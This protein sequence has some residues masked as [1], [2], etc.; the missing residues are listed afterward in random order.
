MATGSYTLL[1]YINPPAGYVDISTAVTNVNL[2]DN[3][4]TVPQ[5]FAGIVDSANLSVAGTSRFTGKATFDTAPDF[6]AGINVAISE[7]DTGTL[8][9][10]GASSLNGGLTVAGSLALPASSIVQSMVSSGY[11][12]L[13]NAQ[14]I[15]GIKTLSSPPVMSGAS[16]SSA[17]IPDSALS[18]NVA[19][20][21]GSQTFSGAKTFSSAVTVPAISASGLISGSAGLTISTG[22]TSLRACSSTGFTASGPSSF[23]DVTAVT[24]SFAGLS[25]SAGVTVTAGNSTLQDTLV[26]GVLTVSSIVDAGALSVGALLSANNGITVSNAVGTFNGGIS[27]STF[28]ASGSASFNT[29]QA[30]GAVTTQANLSVNGSAAINGV[31]GLSVANGTSTLKAATCTDLTVINTIVGTA[32]KVVISSDNTNGVYPIPFTKVGG[33]NTLFCDD[34]VTPV[35]SYNPSNGTLSAGA[36]T[37]AGIITGSGGLNLT[38]SVV[39]NIGIG[40]VVNTANDVTIALGGTTFGTYSTTPSA[41]VNTLTIT[42][43]AVCATFEILIAP[44]AAITWRKAMSS[45]GVTIYNNLAGNQAM[46]NGS[47]WWVK[48]KCLSATIIYLDFMNVT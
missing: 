16:I 12:D 34:T 25:A 38:G 4:F 44:T 43:G 35:L 28:S 17:S 39:Y 42:G 33:S 47:R 20:L 41:N 13:A 8:I 21:S 19:L 31:G 22:A 14:T 26:S 23:Q 11:V 29:I 10:T 32:S 36:V 30:L 37:S 6:L 48:G 24:G 45:G 9:V 5:T 27:T 40:S 46:A 15:A 2:V 18:A 1:P 7:V 3:N